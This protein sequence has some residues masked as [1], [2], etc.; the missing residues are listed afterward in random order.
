MD[1]RRAA[2]ERICGVLREHGYRALFAGG[3]VRD[4]L[5]ETSPKDYDVATNARPDEV[6]HLFPKTVA[7][8]A[9]YGVMLVVLPEG[10][11]EVATFRGDGP[12]LD[13]RH[14]SQV[15]FLGEREDALRR[16][17]T[18]NAMFY[19]P[20]RDEVVDYVGGQHDLENRVIRT[21]GDAETRFSEDHLRLMRAIRFSARLDFVMD[22]ATHDAIR[23]LA[24]AIRTVSAERIRDELTKM[25]T[26]GGARRAFELMDQTGL[27]EQVLP[28]VS[29]M[30]GVGQPPE[31]HPEGDVFVHTMMV[32]EHLKDASPSLAFGALLHDVGKPPTA[33]FS[34][35]I[36]FNNHDKVGAKMTRDICRRLRMS[37]EDTD[38][39]EWL[40]KQHM[41]LAHAPDMR[42]SKLKRFVRED[43]FRELLELGRIDCLAS[44]GD[45]DTISWIS[46]YLDRHP[47]EECR[48]APLVTGKELIAMGYRPGPLFKEILSA[49][50]DAQLEGTVSTAAEAQALV[51]EHWP[52]G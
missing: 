30:K 25:L 18:I 16:D 24:P 48:P 14:P 12:Y 39:I 7:V 40:V 50:E 27:L 37:N 33:T 6:A 20:Q 11:F 38:R 52:L 1:D 8:G 31:F 45:L 44:H 34:D 5:L 41:R 46:D 42:E 13:G 2:A 19:D 3:C 23:A 21:V 9:V 17:F 43:G 29:Q 26:E 51:R 35:R 15:E 22:D 28:E 47:K 10:N 49:V 36:R 32:L 4:L